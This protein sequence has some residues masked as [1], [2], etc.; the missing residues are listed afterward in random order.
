MW[1][2]ITGMDVASAWSMGVATEPAAN[3]AADFN[4]SRLCTLAS[5]D[6]RVRLARNLVEN[7]LS[8]MKGSTLS[9]NVRP[10]ELAFGVQAHAEAR[11]VRHFHSSIDRNRFIEQQ[12]SSLFRRGPL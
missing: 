1:A 5:P 3:T 2:S 10:V 7:C 8:W 9:M 4:S 6:E 11:S 12:L